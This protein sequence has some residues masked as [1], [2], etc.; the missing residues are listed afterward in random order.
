MTKARVIIF[1]VC[2]LLTMLII[3]YNSKNTIKELRAEAAELED[4]V[5]T[6]ESEIEELKVK[7]EDKESAI[8]S[9]ILLSGYDEYSNLNNE[10]QNDIGDLESEVLKLQNKLDDCERNLSY[11][12]DK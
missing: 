9:L 10:L 4:N 2:G 6:L 12:N 8:S 3:T 1:L 11:S 7:L 5:Y